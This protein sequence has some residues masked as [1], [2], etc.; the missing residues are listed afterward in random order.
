MRSSSVATVL[1]A[2]L[3]LSVPASAQVAGGQKYF[4][5]QK[6]FAGIDPNY[7]PAYPG[8]WIVS[9]Q[10]TGGCRSGSKAHT[11]T[12]TCSEPGMCNPAKKPIST[13]RNLACTVTCTPWIENTRGHGVI[14]NQIAVSYMYK[15]N[16][17]DPDEQQV[18]LATCGK[19]AMDPG[20][21]Y[22]G[23]EWDKSDGS[24]F[25]WFGK[26]GAP[27]LTGSAM[28]GRRLSICDETVAAP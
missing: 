18:V 6:L 26:E 23:C 1:L 25:Y 5:R 19:K 27:S 7:D 10:A 15:P 22:Y 3:A 21:E 8:T 17:D 11:A 2:V 9:W 4:A 13:V 20:Y 12:Y 28:T 16:Y 24:V 14:G